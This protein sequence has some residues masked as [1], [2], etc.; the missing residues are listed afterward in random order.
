MGLSSSQAR[1]LNLTARM[2]Q[3][4]YK[5]AKLEAQKLQMA[6]ES[7]RVYEDYLEALDKTK[8]QYK[9]LTTDGSVTYR[10]IQQY[11]DFTG[12]GYALHYKGITFDGQTK[13]KEG[14][15]GNFYKTGATLP[16]G[17][18]LQGAEK[19]ANWDT[20]LKELGIDKV[21]GD[22]ETSISTNTGLQEVSD[23][24][25]LRKAEAKYEADMKKIDNK[26][27]KFDTDLAALDTERNAIKQE[28]ETLKTVAKENVERTFK[29]FS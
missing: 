12:A 5:A 23:E 20:L 10:D 28:M 14:S 11:S 1:L 24:V 15:D 29:L 7:T 13:Y 18:T 4:E 17:V 19:T 21:S 9:V 22:Y 25:E 16:N 2:H 27:R 6:N 8:V 3:I 26:D